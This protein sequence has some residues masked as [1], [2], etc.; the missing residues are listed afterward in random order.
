MSK[1]SPFTELI[2]WQKSRIFRNQI[3]QFIKLLPSEEKYRLTDQI[4]R[5][6][7]S[8]TAN[9]AEGHGKFHHKENIQSCRVARGEL[10]ETLDHLICAYDCNYIDSEQLKNFKAKIDEIH[11]ILN[12]YIKF[13]KSQ[14][15]K[16]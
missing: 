7:R 16:K 1:Y 12:G 10:L 6:S 2:V 5:S 9:I 8:I 3:F 11:K 14:L 15:D 4:V 13:L